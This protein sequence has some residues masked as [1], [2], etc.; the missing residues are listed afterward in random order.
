MVGA[1]DKGLDKV[2]RREVRSHCAQKHT[3]FCGGP[4]THGVRHLGAVG[5]AHLAGNEEERRH[6]RSAEVE[7]QVVQ[8]REPGG[9]HVDMR[10]NAG[11]WEH[12]ETE[13]G[14][15]EEVGRQ[16]RIG[17]AGKVSD[18]QNIEQLDAWMKAGEVPTT[19]VGGHSGSRTEEKKELEK[20]RQES[21]RED[22]DSKFERDNGF[23]IDTQKYAVHR[24]FQRASVIGL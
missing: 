23:K 6:L 7:D 5:E 4:A 2:R 13:L 12:R 20:H 16:R 19:G 9:F 1:P 18:G 8:D 14:V 21:E 11:S 17:F 15:G 3:S 10:S 24:S 22:F